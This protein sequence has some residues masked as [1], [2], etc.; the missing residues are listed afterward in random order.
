MKSSFE[1]YRILV[2]VI[3]E[4]SAAKLSK[5]A[6]GSYFY[7]PKYATVTRQQRNEAIR[8]DY[9]NGMTINQLHRKY[10]LTERQIRKITHLK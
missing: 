4:E 1:N 9:S 5:F 7:V 2:E 8:R 3:G 10:E 6:D